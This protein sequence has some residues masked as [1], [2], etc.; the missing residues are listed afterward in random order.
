MAN[1]KIYSQDNQLLKTF[2]IAGDLIICNLIFWFFQYVFKLRNDDVHTIYQSMIASS[3]IYIACVIRNGVVLYHPQVKK[4]QIGIRVLN[5]MIMFVIMQVILFQ[6]GG[7]F[8]YEKFPMILYWALMAV[9]IYLF[10]ITTLYFLKIYRVRGGQ[11]NKIILVGGNDII[12]RLYN[13]LSSVA[14]VGSSV[15]GY[16][17][18]S[19]IENISSKCP[20]LGRPSDITNYLSK[21]PEVHALFCSLPSSREKEITVFIDY[22]LSNFVHFYSVPNVSNY[23]HHRMHLNIIGSVPYLSL[24][25]EPL[26]RPKNR[27][28]KRAFDIA[29]S[30]LFLCTLFPIVFIVVAIITKI[31]MPGPIFFRQKRNGINA[32]EFYC[33]KFR[34]MR[35]NDEADTKQATKDD[36]RKTRWGEIMRKTNIDELPQFVNVLLGDMSIVGPRPH[37]TKHTETYSKMISNYMVRHYIKPGIT[38]WSQVTGFRGETRELSQMEGRIRGDIWYIENWSFWLDIYIIYKTVANAIMGDDAAY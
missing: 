38:G 34:S 23:L 15:V 2:V 18:D 28:L 1:K 12:E 25:R 16:F 26:S 22:C 13:E 7:F 14:D 6:L 24:Y 29:F 32:R 19:P 20:Y 9:C 4:H 11:N 37:M 30:A 17:Y 33:L 21:H 10:R 3:V 27:L 8:R 31:T 35:V 5:N 36:P